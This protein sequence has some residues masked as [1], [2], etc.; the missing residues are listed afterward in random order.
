MLKKPKISC[1]GIGILRA[2]ILTL[3][4][5]IGYTF[6]VTVVWG[7][8]DNMKINSLFIMV[9]SCISIL[10]GSICATRASGEKGWL[11]GLMVSIL[12]ILI[13]YLISIVAGRDA[14]ISSKDIVRAIIAMVVGT[15]SGMIGINI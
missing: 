8:I 6:I 15:L 4:C 10:Y 2:T 11:M 5:F 13:I 7:S 3:I 12:Y 9:F 1:V 14:A